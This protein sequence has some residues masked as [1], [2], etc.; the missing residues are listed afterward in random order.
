MFD[1]ATGLV[2][3]EVADHWRA[4]W[5]LSQIIRKRWPELKR[6]LDGKIHVIAGDKDEYRLDISARKLE[7]A[8]RAVGGNASFTYVPG[9]GHYDLYGEGG[10]RMAL[11]R[12]IGWRMWQAAYPQSGLSDPGPPAA[13]PAA[14]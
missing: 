13:A 4:N 7:D 8:F 2:N 11:R 12:K 5:D 10:E 14:R 1:R 6:D 9:K 3:R